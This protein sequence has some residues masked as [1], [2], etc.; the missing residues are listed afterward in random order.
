MITDE[1]KVEIFEQTG[2]RL[3]GIAYRMLGTRTDTEDILQEAYI[4]WHKADENEIETPEAWLVTIVTRLSIDRL[5]KA[6]RERETYIGPWLPEPLIT[7]NAPSPEEEVELASNLSLAF[8]V[9]LERLSPLERAVFLLH[10]VFDCGYEEIARI[11]GKSETASRQIIHRAR[12]R[13]KNDK[14]R[15]EA[16]E[17]EQARLIEKFVAA[18]YSGDEKTLLSLFSEEISSVSDGGGKVTAA[19]KILRG[20]NRIVRVFSI[21]GA[22]YGKVLKNL[23]IPINGETGLLTLFEGKPFA[24]TAFEFEDGKIS[25]MYRVMNPDKLK[26]FAELD[27][28]FFSREQ[29]RA[30]H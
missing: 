5:R 17:K 8:M 13:V 3:F 14:P 7:S 26:A 2:K 27:E 25:A 19:R 16:D 4:R 29:T 28:N 20:K 23:I 6:S 9:L 21:L 1:K 11:V 18:S 10:D 15:F 24:V 12:T 30:F 22:K